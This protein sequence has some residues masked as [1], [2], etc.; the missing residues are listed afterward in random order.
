MP[1]RHSASQHRQ[2][3]LRLIVL[4]LAVAAVGVPINHLLSYTLLLIA[5]VLIFSGQMIAKPSA[6]L[7]AVVAVLIAV[8]LP[9]A[10]APAPIAEGEN[11]FLPAKPGNVFEQ[12]MPPDVYR[13]MQAE[14]DALYPKSQRCAPESVGC[15]QGQGQPSDLYAFSADGVFGKPLY[16]RSVTAIDFSD[17]VWLRLGFIN[18]FRYNWYTDAPDVHRT[19]RNRAFYMGL[20]RWNVTMPWFAMFQFPADYVGGSLCWR[21]DVL[22]EGADQRYQI[23]RHTTT[24]CRTLAAEDVGRKIFGVV[25]RP[26]TLAMTLHPPAMVEARLIACTIA[27]LLAVIAVLVRLSGTDPPGRPA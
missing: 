15:W 2:L 22:W 17:P 26:D 3:T 12:K 14:F 19:D 1:D 10:L 23:L 7:A 6:W 18:D 5:A 11:I 20:R 24:A 21:G 9:P 27:R 4:M 8:L 13:F 25:I 16:S